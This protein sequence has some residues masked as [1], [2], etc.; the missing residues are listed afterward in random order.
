M[1]VT[2]SDIAS[3]VGV[4]PST[5]QRALNDVEGVSD[6]KRREIKTVAAAMGYRRNYLASSLK[7]GAI[8]IALVLPE[9]SGSNRY[10]A[11]FLW[12]GAKS[13]IQGFEQFNFK[14]Y[15]YVYDRKAEEE[16][17]VLQRVME[18]HASSID[19][20]ITM[21]T[22]NPKQIE[23]LEKFKEKEIPVVLVGTDTP[24]KDL[25]V[26]CVCTHNETAGRMAAD[27][28]INFSGGAPGRSVILSGDFSISDQFLNAQGFEKGIIEN[29]FPIE[30]T[31]M[32]YNKNQ[33]QVKASMKALLSSGLDIFAMYSCSARNTV[34]MCEAVAELG[35]DG[36][37]KLIGSD[38]F[39]EA[40]EYAQNRKLSAII[41]KRPS[42]QAYDGVQVL[43]ST[44]VKNQSKIEDIK[45]VEPVVVM[46]SNLSCY[47]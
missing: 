9:Q 33:E 42:A 16:G 38:I 20:I 24:R 12:E 28:L 17:E 41:H 5:V 18:K 4:T 13:A 36:K 6:E 21:G 27:L 45:Y 2:L 25:R 39:P 26:C 34:S 29:A 11:R 43:V 46:H 47:I 23:M 10:Y 7:K 32:A 31:K 22:N 30:I 40:I 3:K 44:I 35:L 37:I 14:T 15:N 1:K 19:G 8:N